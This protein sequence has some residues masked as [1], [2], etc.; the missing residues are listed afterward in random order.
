MSSKDDRMKNMKMNRFSKDIY[1]MST[2]A[3]FHNGANLKKKSSYIFN[4]TG[5]K[6]T[7]FSEDGK[8]SKKW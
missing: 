4:K 8:K 7:F 3:W 6:T 2:F 5:L 1:A